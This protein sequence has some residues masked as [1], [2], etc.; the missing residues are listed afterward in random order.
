[1]DGVGVIDGGEYTYANEALAGIHGLETGQDLV[2]GQWERWYAP[3]RRAAPELLADARETGEWRGSV[4]GLKRGGGQVPLQLSLRASDGEVVCVAREVTERLERERRLER[5]ETILETVDDGVY[6]LDEELRVEMANERFFELLARFGFTREEV[7]EMHAHDLV[8]NDDERAE[9]EATIERAIEREPHVGSFEMSAETPEGDTVVCESRFRLY[10]EPD[11][12]H[13]GCIGI[14]RDVTDR[15]ERERR[16]ERQRDELDTLNRINEL[17]L[18]VSRD[19]FESAGRNGVEQT[20]CTRLVASDLYQFAW[21]GKPGA[22]DERL[23][24]VASAGV[25]DD[26]VESIPV[27]A[28]EG[29]TGRGPSGRAFRTGTVQVSHDIETDP[30]FEPWREA[31]LERDLR[32]AAAIPLTYDGTTYGVLTV[33]ASRPLAFS[34]RER[35]GFEIL[36]KAIGYA[37]NATRTRQLLFAEHVVE[38]ELRLATA[39]AFLT[40][41]TD[42]L[43]CGLSLA[44][45]VSTGPDSWLLYLSLSGVDAGR[46][47]DAVR[48]TTAVETVRTVKD[49]SERV[50]ALT[51]RWPL[52][53]S[54]AALGGRVTSMAVGDGDGTV[55]VE[56]PQ[57]TDVR[58][59]VEQIRASHSETELLAKREEE[60][61]RDQSARFAW[62]EVVELTDRQRQALE[63]AYHAGYFEWP[64][65]SSAEDVAELLDI[66]RPT[67]QAHIRKAEQELL[68]ELFADS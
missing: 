21:V 40:D 19:L 48:A 34:Q 54:L 61:S 18:A 12:D 59:F 65:E 27:T 2:G 9:L 42:R 23:V 13:R 24:S 8:V 60:R 15:I 52:L 10:P 22:T 33:Y 44:G 35:R 47:A 53:D 63:A 32:S 39:G 16:L 31:A 36:G 64:R 56:I 66:S 46:F 37:L 28:G 50:V 26:C 51:V 17:L 58:E 45:Y 25:G 62:M 5:Y 41:I 11:G 38:L 20:V 43:G 68:T 4:T 1:M 7:R 30:T 67:L 6:V 29:E 3:E 55:V 14:L 49:S 57:S